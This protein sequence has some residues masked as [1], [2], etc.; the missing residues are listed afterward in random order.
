[1]GRQILSA[2]QELLSRF[3]YADKQGTP[4]TS[5]IRRT[6]NLDAEVY[7]D[8]YDGISA[9]ELNNIEKYKMFENSVSPLLP[10]WDEPRGLSSFICLPD[11]L[12][13]KDAELSSI[14]CDK[15]Q[16]YSSA[17]DTESSSIVYNQVQK[18]SKKKKKKK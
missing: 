12:K 18:S 15:A 17:K 3:R 2:S 13:Y 4:N 8:L 9:N 10:Y 14:G 1:M 5:K 11:Y 6:E 7:P 16:D